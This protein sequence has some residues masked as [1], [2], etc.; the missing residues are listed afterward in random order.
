MSVVVFPP[1]LGARKHPDAPGVAGNT[2]LDGWRQFQCFSAGRFSAMPLPVLRHS[3]PQ[4][5]VRQLCEEV[6]EVLADTRDAIE[7]LAVSHPVPF[8]YNAGFPGSHDPLRLPH[9][10]SQ[11]LVAALAAPWGVGPGLHGHHVS[12]PDRLLRQPPRPCRGR[13]GEEGEGVIRGRRSTWI[14]H[15]FRAP[16]S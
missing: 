10:L 9:P 8:T 2:F 15:R 11:I 5:P 16:R 14:A 3:L 1:P 7:V 13:C 12:I 4:R 6:A